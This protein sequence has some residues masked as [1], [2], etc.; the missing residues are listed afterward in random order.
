MSRPLREIRSWSK[1]LA[2]TNVFSDA[3]RGAGFAGG[4]SSDGDYVAN[5]HTT[6]LAAAMFEGVRL[7]ISQNGSE[8]PR[9]FTDGSGKV[10]VTYVGWKDGNQQHNVIL[11]CSTDAGATFSAP[12]MVDAALAGSTPYVSTGAFARD[13]S[14]LIAEV[15]GD[16]GGGH[17]AVYVAVSPKGGSLGTPKRVNTYTLPGENAPAAASDVD[18]RVDDQGIVWLSYG[19]EGWRV[20]VDKSCDGGKTWSGPVLVNGKAGGEIDYRSPSGL[21]TFDGGRVGVLAWGLVPGGLAPETL[22][23]FPLFPR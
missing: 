9:L 16:T 1:S 7:A 2:S 20:I 3:H 18:L 22:S 15:A 5:G 10:C 13:G 14:M 12:T 4:Q 19:V 17:G 8:P 21:V 6:G 11:Q 23:L